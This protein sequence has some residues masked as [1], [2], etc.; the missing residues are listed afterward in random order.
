MALDINI[1]TGLEKPLEKLIETISKGTGVLY[2]DTIGV[3][4]T[5]KRIKAIGKAE[6]EVEKFSIIKKA[7]ANRDAY[8]I[9][10]GM[11]LND[12]AKL[13]VD[14]KENRRQ[15]NLE[16][17]I[18]IAKENL[19]EKVSDDP[20]DMDWAVRFFD[21]AQD[22][23]NDEMRFIWGKILAGEV[24]KP[25]SFSIRTLEVLKNLDKEDA[26]VFTE[27]T[28]F[29]SGDTEDDDLSEIIKCGNDTKILDKC[30]LSYNKII[31]L[32]DANLIL[33]GDS[34]GATW[35]FEESMTL[36]NCGEEIKIK[37]KGGKRDIQIPVFILTNAGREI[38]QIIE[39]QKNPTY[40][41]ELRNYLNKIGFEVIQKERG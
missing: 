16:K 6:A 40:I 3:E 17:T 20:V 27:I 31:S 30:G 5:V 15:E 25:G 1:K 29:V 7:E 38:Y 37:Y 13:R 4:L 33:N 36:I 28:S 11:S 32:R 34:I 10:R 41:E 8:L 18:S 21:I 23:N 12:R 9:E 26:K 19:P 2:R 24:K 14:A 22:I 39:S 35:D